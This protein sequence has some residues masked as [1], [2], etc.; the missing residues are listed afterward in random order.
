MYSCYT[1]TTLAAVH[2]TIQTKGIFSHTSH[3]YKYRHYRSKIWTQTVMKNAD[4]P[5]KYINQ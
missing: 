4:V 3:S 2:G 1:T 5:N